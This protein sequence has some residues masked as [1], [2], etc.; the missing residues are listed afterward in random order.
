MPSFKYLYPKSDS[1][2]F[3]HGKVMEAKFNTAQNPNRVTD[4]N[5]FH[6]TIYIS[7][8]VMP[9][10]LMRHRQLVPIIQSRLKGTGKT[11]HQ[12]QAL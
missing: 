7:P 3:G 8:N 9:I 4:R 6:L 1:P 5:L 10:R 12:P 11:R 2:S